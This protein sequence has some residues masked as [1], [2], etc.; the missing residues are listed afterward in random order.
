MFVCDS[1]LELILVRREPV[2]I[3]FPIL[4]LSRSAVRLACWLPS[5]MNSRSRGCKCRKWV[6]R[7]FFPTT[8]YEMGHITLYSH[9]SFTS[10]IASHSTPR[11]LA[12]RLL[13]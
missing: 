2:Q 6:I 1:V 10:V 5:W 9:S 3:L 11:R 13:L 8:F 7:A 12:P 4:E